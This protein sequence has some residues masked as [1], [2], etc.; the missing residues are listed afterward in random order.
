[1]G[2]R[3][4]QAGGALQIPFLGAGSRL[5]S[6][7]DPIACPGCDNVSLRYY[8]HVFNQ[9]KRQGTLWFWCSAC[10]TTCHLPRVIPK[11]AMPNDPFHDL[12]LEE[13]ARLEME[14]G[15]PFQDR[16]DRMWTEGLLQIS[17]RGSKR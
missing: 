12:D 14:L 11:V 10:R 5:L 8:F 15:E 1:M 17:E 2:K 16:L 9:D 4:K 13:F 6:E 3:W 7:K